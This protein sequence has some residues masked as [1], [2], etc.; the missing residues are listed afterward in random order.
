MTSHYHLSVPHFC[1]VF[2]CTTQSVA[3]ITLV[4]VS[5][6]YSLFPPPS[7]HLWT[8]C[9]SSSKSSMTSVLLYCQISVLTLTN[10]LGIADKVE[11]FVLEIVSPDSWN[12]IPTSLTA[13]LL[14]LFIWVHLCTQFL[15]DSW[16]CT[17]FQSGTSQ[18]TL[19]H[20]ENYTVSYS[21]LLS[22]ALNSELG[23]VTL[24]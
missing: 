2:Y 16:D 22:L 7:S 12:T 9:I 14:S 21:L 24:E 8:H 6:F 4:P 23:H 3:L 20:L 10:F 15:H 1:V 11:R 5:F 13:H 18:S 19:T 17:P